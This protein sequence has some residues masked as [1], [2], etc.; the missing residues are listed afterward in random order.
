MKIC[1]IGLEPKKKF[2]YAIHAQFQTNYDIV[3]R[4][5][6]NFPF[7]SNLD[8]IVLIGNQNF[9]FTNEE[10]LYE[11][12]DKAE[13]KNIPVVGVFREN[14]GLPKKDKGLSKVIQPCDNLH[15]V[16][17]A[18]QLQEFFW[19]YTFNKR[20]QKQKIAS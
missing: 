9:V 16:G 19:D 6:R 14:E 4:V 3:K 18:V 15:V 12:L 7:T 20:T 11:F 8:G 5:I 10:I 17:I 2:I 13:Q 1:Y